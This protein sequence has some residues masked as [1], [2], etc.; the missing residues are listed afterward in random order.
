MKTRQSHANF[1]RIITIVLG[2]AFG[3]VAITMFYAAFISSTENRSKAAGVSNC[4][5]VCKTVYTYD[6]KLRRTVPKLQ[7]MTSCPTPTPTP[8]PAAVPTPVPTC[9]VKDYGCTLGASYCGSGN[10]LYVCQSVYSNTCNQ[11]VKTWIEHSCGSGTCQVVSGVAKCVIQA[12]T[13]TPTVAPT[14]T[15]RPISYA[16]QV[17]YAYCGSNNS[18]DYNLITKCISTTDSCGK[19]ITTW[20]S[21]LCATGTRCVSTN[22]TPQCV[23]AYVPQ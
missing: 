12:S 4:R 13:P 1:R 6:S 18:V 20:Q 2:I 8:R 15:C 19:T 5:R 21:I 14:A 17:G 23:K 7:C 16:C 9:A 11:N 3:I 22:G 10:A